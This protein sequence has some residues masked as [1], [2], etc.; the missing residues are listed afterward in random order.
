MLHLHLGSA[1]W[2]ASH[3]LHSRTRRTKQPLS[4]TAETKFTLHLKVS[5]GCGSYTSCLHI[6]KQSNSVDHSQERWVGSCSLTM[7]LQKR[8]KLILANNGDNLNVVK[9]VT[10]AGAVQALTSAVHKWNTAC[11]LC[12]CLQS[13]IAWKYF[14]NC[15]C[16]KHVQIFLL[17]WFPKQCNSY[18]H[19]IYIILSIRSNLEMI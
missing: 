2:C 10:V 5:P 16:A 19:G 3:I 13:T 8:E 6:F 7:C 15:I 1:K 9:A 4:V 11:S 12:L 14:L 18:L 17:S